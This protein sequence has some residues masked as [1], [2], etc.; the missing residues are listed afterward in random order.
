MPSPVV[1]GKFC[2]RETQAPKYSGKVWSD[3][4]LPLI[5]EDQIRE[6]LKIHGIPKSI[7]PGVMHP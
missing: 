3:E 5:E 4:D 7:G 1:I 2:F 6:H